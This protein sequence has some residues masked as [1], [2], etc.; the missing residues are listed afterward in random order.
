[1][2]ILLPGLGGSMCVPRTIAAL[3]TV[4]FV[5]GPKPLDVSRG[6][7]DLGSQRGMPYFHPLLARLDARAAIGRA[8]FITRL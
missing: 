6:L 2:I 1:M 5:A 4:A 7:N 3:R 8:S